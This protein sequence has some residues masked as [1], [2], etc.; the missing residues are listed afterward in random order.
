MVGNFGILSLKIYRGLGALRM[1]AKN[2]WFYFRL[3]H[4]EVLKFLIGVCLAV[5]QHLI[6]AVRGRHLCHSVEGWWPD[7]CITF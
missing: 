7:T 5:P 1:A 4:K 2:W 6:L 3:S